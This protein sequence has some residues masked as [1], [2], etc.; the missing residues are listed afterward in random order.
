[1]PEPVETI[2]VVRVTNAAGQ[3][4]ADEVAR[5]T[6][7]TIYVNDIELVTLLC[8]PTDPKDLAVGFLFSEGIVSSVRDISNFS[9]NESKGIAWVTLADGVKFS[10]SDYHRGRAVTSGCARGQTFAHLTEKLDIPPISS[11]AKFT[12]DKVF[13]LIRRFQS[14]GG[15]GSLFARTGCVHVALL[16]SADEI[17]VY[18]EDIGRHN[19]VDK[20][21][22]HCVLQG[23]ECS[24]KAIMVTG[25]LSSEMV[26]KA[27]RL[28]VPL[29]ISRT[30]PTSSALKIADEVG[31]TLIGFARGQRMNIYS[32]PYRINLNGSSGHES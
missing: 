23:I 17:V 3:Q 2:K 26:T 6:P 25:R 30:A 15:S 20:V 22:G 31:L 16:M 14:A 8:S 9:L 27:A 12:A 5:E 18:R 1:M 11:L 24:D 32:H 21:V 10:E 28:G 4:V 7:L 13:E 29:V 19:A